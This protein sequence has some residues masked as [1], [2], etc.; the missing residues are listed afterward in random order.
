[1]SGPDD[2]NWSPFGVSKEQLDFEGEQAEIT[3]PP[4]PDAADVDEA[5]KLEDLRKLQERQ[6][7][8]F[9]RNVFSTEVGRREM[10]GLLKDTGLY[11]GPVHWS[12]PNG[13][14]DHYATQY[15]NGRRDLGLALF[16]R[17]TLLDR[18]GVFAML[19]ENDSA[20]MKAAT[21]G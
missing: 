12:G 6:A 4:N 8:D 15:F 2:P 3:P 10:Y 13:A 7:R 11:G 9:W 21:N 20:F 19:D 14:P 5:K 16:L 17:W 18:P 1:M